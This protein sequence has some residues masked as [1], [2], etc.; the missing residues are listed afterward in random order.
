MTAMKVCAVDGCLMPSTQVDHIVPL[1]RGGPALDRTNL[2]A[3]CLHHNSS[4]GARLDF[5][6]R[7]HCECRDPSC[8]GRW[9]L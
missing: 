2:Q 5:P 7:R 9:H 6:R 4:K 3:M 8:P 1:A